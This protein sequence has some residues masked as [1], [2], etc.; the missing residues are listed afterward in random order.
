MEKC[1]I[2]VGMVG[3]SKLNT[4]TSHATIS[5]LSIDQAHDNTTSHLYN[6]FTSRAQKLAIN[7]TQKL[8]R[9]FEDLYNIHKQHDTVFLS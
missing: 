9:A 6:K 1:G 7:S 3:Y 2:S 4:K 8:H 5:H